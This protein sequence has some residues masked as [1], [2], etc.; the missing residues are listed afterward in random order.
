[1]E[2]LFGY[3]PLQ[4]ERLDGGFDDKYTIS[5]NRLGTHGAGK[6]DAAGRGAT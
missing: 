5:Y 4:D 2:C 6:P 1:M 3:L